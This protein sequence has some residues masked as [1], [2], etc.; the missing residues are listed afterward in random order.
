MWYAHTR[1]GVPPGQWEPLAAHLQLVAEGGAALPGA[2]GFA[3]AFHAA[4]WGRLLGSWHDVGK[5]STAFQEYLKATADVSKAAAPRSPRV[6]HSTAGA[7][8]AVRSLPGPVG[9]LLAYCIAGHHAGLPDA[10][11]AGGLGGSLRARLSKPVEPIDAAPPEWLAVNE[12]PRP[13]A[14]VR[15]ETS[16]DRAFSIAFFARM[17]FSCLVDADYLATEHFMQPER[18]EQRAGELPEMAALRGALDAYLAEV[19]RDARPTPVNQQ[20]A[21]VLAACRAAA[22][23]PPG[24]F[25]L[26]VPTGGGKTL[27]SLAFAL[28]HAVKHGLRRVIYAIPFTS[29]IEQNAAVFRKAV[30]SASAHAVLE[31]HSNFD[32]PVTSER[33]R[34]EADEAQTPWHRLAAENWDAPLVVTTNVQLFESLFASKPSRCRKLHRIARSVI[35]LDE[36]QTLP[37]DL[38]RPTLAAIRELVRNYGCTAVLCTAT[39]PAL[40]R[41]DE[42][43]IGLTDVREIVPDPP[44]LFQ[45]LKRVDVQLIGRVEDNE[46]VERLAD[47]PRA[48]CIVN[49][50]DHAA[51]IYTMLHARAEHGGPASGRLA[52]DAGA[53]PSLWHLSARM[54]PAHRS[55]VIEKIRAALEAGQPC[56][57][58]ST[59]LVEA[60]VDLDFP[61]VYRAMAGLDSI[62]QAAGRCNREG[63]SDR[64]VTYVFESETAP[65]FVRATAD[66][67]REIAG[68]H[69]A[70]L[71]SPPAIEAYFRLHFW[72]NADRCDEKRVMDCFA[73]SNEGGHLQFRSAAERYCYIE[74]DQ[75][76]VV[77]P[78]GEKGEAFA[79]RVR[80]AEQVS[81]RDLFRS[82][83]S[84]TVNLYRD[85]HRRLQESGAITCH[86][87]GLWLLEDSHAYDDALGLQAYAAGVNPGGLIVDG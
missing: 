9:R 43:P 50:R 68:A 37:V 53:Q 42:F 33:G 78:Y 11:D 64:G 19:A 23:L 7:Q 13:P 49:T 10:E 59:Q 84:F 29:I 35:I 38:L 81:M 85:A 2:A 32:P 17:L 71:L 46:L 66:S 56:R 28:G 73:P 41:R 76:P 45:A 82:A 36:V 20:R 79:A 77:V 55:A 14:L 72:K 12:V 47:Q 6:D 16:R 51:A 63:R 60:G 21:H 4:A 39:Q 54:C 69:A 18:A 25:S 80:Q 87:D 75:L 24:L 61:I 26:T 62:A 8:H 58:I 1:S 15:Q 67:A 22:T 34:S 27:S 40:H 31:H 86:H 74:N 5:Y 48:L 65:R 70:D 57:V 3:E 30:S 83:Q 44:A 52:A